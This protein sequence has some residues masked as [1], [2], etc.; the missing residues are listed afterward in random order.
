VTGPTDSSRSGREEAGSDDRVD[1]APVVILGGL[2]NALSVGRSL[3]A[4]GIPVHF[5]GDRWAGL[6][7]SRYC[8]EFVAI[9]PGEPDRYWEPLLARGPGR[10][11]VIPCGDDA[12]E[13]VAHRREG[14]EAAGYLPIEAHDEGLLAMLD[15]ECAYDIARASDVR[16]PRTVPVS[17][18]DELRVAVE[19]IGLPAA[20]KPRVSHAFARHFAGKAVVETELASAI[21]TFQQMRAKG[22][23]VVLTEI[24]PGPE[25]SYWGYYTYVDEGGE[26]Q[27]EFTKRKLRQYPLGFGLGTLHRMERNEAVIAVGRKFV[28]GAGL[29]GLVN[30]EFKEDSRD[31]RYVFIECNHRITAANELMVAAGI[32]LGSYVYDR[33][34]GDRPAPVEVMRDDLALWWPIRD[35]A[36]ALQMFFAGELTVRGWLAGFRGRILFPAVRVTDPVP[37]ISSLLRG[38]ARLPAR[39][40]RLLRA[41]RA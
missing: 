36:A 10:G 25:G 21:A 23:D 17:D 39:V 9:G 13:F 5:F 12:L 26:L 6:R 29:R 20:L 19:M 37:S 33:V 28:E 34:V 4:R 15:K 3:G 11:V 35:T 24:I 14:L 8:R 31:G 22:I 1:V 7:F 27:W 30:A 32:D 2:A 18:V 16:C 40:R 41:S 38:V